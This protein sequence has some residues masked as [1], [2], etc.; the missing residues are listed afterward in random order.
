[1]AIL[2]IVLSV[3]LPSTAFI[4]LAV[5]LWK[6][7]TT[8][9]RGG[10]FQPRGSLAVEAIGGVGVTCVA[11]SWNLLLAAAAQMADIRGRRVNFVDVIPDPG[12]AA[13]IVAPA[14]LG[15]AVGVI[16][17]RRKQKSTHAGRLEPKSDLV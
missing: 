15:A 16:A 7:G 10:T 8:S 5:L 14:A 17:L 1:M 2:D 9:R 12:L 6:I 4:G 3:I 11:A 13:I